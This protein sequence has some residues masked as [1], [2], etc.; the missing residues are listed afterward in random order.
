[1]YS[2]IK[3]PH[4]FDPRDGNNVYNGCRVK[5]TINQ[6]TVESA[7]ITHNF[8]YNSSNNPES[9]SSDGVGTANPNLIFKYDGK[10][11]L[12]EY[13]GIYPNG[14]FE[15][16]HKYGYSHNR[17][18]TDTQYVFGT[19]ATLSGY[20]SK[21]YK[22]LSYDYLN[23]IVQ[24]SEVYVFPAPSVN[25]INFSYDATGNLVNGKVYDTKL[26][27][28]R[29]NKIWMFIDRDYS[30]NNPV[31]ANT[32]NSVGLPLT[33]TPAGPVFDLTFAYFYYYGSTQIIY[34]CK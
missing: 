16:V 25:V 21:R 30:V 5:Q 29:T 20:F 23:R 17:I 14:L 15:F 24:D 32:Y 7:V 6:Q 13:S 34:N 12:I 4:D 22:Y 3:P 33:Y 18:V 31:A 26:N 28:H 8:V 1:L 10:G 9:V 27:P 11:R 2:C 19:Y